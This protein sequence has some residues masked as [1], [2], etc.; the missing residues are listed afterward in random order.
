MCRLSRQSFCNQ[1]REAEP[2]GH[3]VPTRASR[4]LWLL[5]SSSGSPACLGDTPE[6]P[7]EVKINIS[8]RCPLK[9]PAGELLLHQ[10]HHSAGSSSCCV[11]PFSCHGVEEPLLPPGH[12]R[13]VPLG[14]PQACGLSS[15]HVSRRLGHVESTCWLPRQCVWGRRGTVCY[16]IILAAPSGCLI[17]P[18]KPAGE[19]HADPK[20]SFLPERLQLSEN[21]FS[22]C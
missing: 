6:P 5:C 8:S 15:Q 1:D 13:H 10:S 3:A 9:L 2:P 16:E 20:C 21:I 4:I 7:N 14:T 11:P 12:H 19:D 18:Q 17:H 22:W